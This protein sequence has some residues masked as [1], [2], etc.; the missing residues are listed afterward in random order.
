M[1]PGIYAQFD[2]TEGSFT[3]RL[4]DKEA[5][6]TVAHILEVASRAPSGHNV[7]PWKVHVLAGTPLENLYVCDASVFPQALGRPTVLTTVSVRSS[8]LPD[9]VI[10]PPAQRVCPVHP[11]R[12]T[13]RVSS[14]L[15][16]NT[17][18]RSSPVRPSGSAASLTSLRTQGKRT[19]VQPRALDA[20][21]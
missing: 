17:F 20:L 7:Q 18:G 19:A 9:V 8:A 4:F 10:S 2:T 16:R 12:T 5:P 6:K 13:T 21:T 11:E 15:A 14:A 1:E 3:I